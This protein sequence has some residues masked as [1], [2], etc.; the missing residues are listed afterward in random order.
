[1]TLI[2]FQIVEPEIPER[3][4]FKSGEVSKLI[5]VPMQT[6][7]RWEGYFP[8][9]RPIQPRRGKHRIY[10]RANVQ[11]AIR[12]R[13]TVRSLKGKKHSLRIAQDRLSRCKAS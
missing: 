11:A 6:L 12:I 1:M 4:Y 8:E 5:G 10:T 3:L 9:L 13:D 7:R 2:R